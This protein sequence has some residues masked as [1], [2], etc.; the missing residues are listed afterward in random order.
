MNAERVEYLF[1]AM[2]NHIQDNCTKE[3]CVEILRAIGM[4]KQEAKDLEFFD[5]ITDQL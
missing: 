5:F 1:E 2:I 3:Q 4:T